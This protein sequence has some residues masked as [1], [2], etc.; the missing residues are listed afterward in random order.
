MIDDFQPNLPLDERFRQAE[1]Y[2][3]DFESPRREQ[4]ATEIETGSC[5][6]HRAF[7]YT[8]RFCNPR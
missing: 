2:S 5:P 1:Q 3:L 6:Y 8:C 4:P 7:V